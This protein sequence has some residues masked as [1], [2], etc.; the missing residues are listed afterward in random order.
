MLHIQSWLIETAPTAYYLTA[1]LGSLYL[2]NCLFIL[3]R[4]ALRLLLHRKLNLVQRYGEKSWALVTGSSDG[5]GKEFALQLAKE[6]FNVILLARTEAKLQAVRQEILKLYPAVKVE[7]IVADLGQ[8]GRKEKA[9]DLLPQLAAFRDISVVVNNAGVDVLDSFTNLAP[10]ALLDLLYL[11]C[12]VLA[13]LNHRFIPLFEER[14][15][16]T[17][18][19]SAIINVGSVAGNT[20]IIQGRRLLRCTTST[21]PARPMSTCS[22]TT[23]PANSP[24]STSSPSSPRMSPPP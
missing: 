3:L 17:G 9:E 7:M 20:P 18:K 15:K 13:A 21:P 8:E 10:S 1:A 14:F 6:G 24:T 16:R 19:R 5:I 2:L 23:S 12:C 11:N 22:P 4:G